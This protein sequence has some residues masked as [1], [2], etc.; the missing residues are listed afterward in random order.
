MRG[1]YPP[2]VKVR[3]GSLRTYSV[4]VDRDEQDLSY[5]NGMSWWHRHSAPHGQGEVSVRFCTLLAMMYHCPSLR[6]TT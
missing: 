1:N 3:G 6:S 4:S 2:C 5:L